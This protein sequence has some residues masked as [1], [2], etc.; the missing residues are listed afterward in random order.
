MDVQQGWSYLQSLLAA[1]NG[2]I[3]ES[4]EDVVR[5]VVGRG[6]QLL[7]A[8]G[9][10]GSATRLVVHDA[11]GIAFAVHTVYRSADI[12]RKYSGRSIYLQGFRY[13]LFH[14]FHTERGVLQVV[15]EQLPQIGCD[16]F[17]VD[18]LCAVVFGLLAGRHM[19]KLFLEGG[20][21]VC[22]QPYVVA[23]QLL[24]VFPAYLLSV[25]CEVLVYQLGGTV[26]DSTEQGGVY[27]CAYLVGSFQS[28]NVAVVES[29][30]AVEVGVEC[31]RRKECVGMPADVVCVVH[32]LQYLVR[33]VYFNL[34]A[35]LGRLPGFQ[36]LA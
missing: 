8:F 20:V 34:E 29:E 30:P 32:P 36:I 12:Q 14:A 21:Y 28:G 6:K 27:L 5:T 15:A 1:H 17:G 7:Y 13:F 24:Q 31:R 4:L 19:E 16:Y 18:K 2:S 26:E 33:L 22:L 3:Q 23:E 11:Q 25:G 35:L 10:L 9:S